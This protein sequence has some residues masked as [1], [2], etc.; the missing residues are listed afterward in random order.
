MVF[1]RSSSRPEVPRRGAAIAL[2]V[3]L[4]W[5]C[6]PGGTM[7][8]RGEVSGE[9]TPAVADSADPTTRSFS[10]EGSRD[11]S[12]PDDEFSE[13]CCGA[14]PEEAVVSE[15]PPR[16]EACRSPGC[17]CVSALAC[18]GG[19]ACGAH[20]NEVRSSEP[21]ESIFRALGCCGDR[22][23]FAVALRLLP[24]LTPICDEA[25]LRL[26]LPGWTRAES[27]DQPHTHAAP[28]PVPPPERVLSPHDSSAGREA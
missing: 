5:G 2:V 11:L 4:L 16:I 6:V 12:L 13:D 8:F 27:L 17:R 7:L 26:P 14:E 25:P 15:R 18:A 1:S 28:P 19:C 23:D 9:T 21:R 20:A 10:L 22:S 3:A 24:P